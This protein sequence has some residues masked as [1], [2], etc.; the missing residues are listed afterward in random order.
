MNILIKPVVTEKSM[1]DVTKSKFTF[2]V[3]RDADKTMIKKEIETQFNVNVIAIR[4]MHVKGKR[5][6]V[7]ARRAEVKESVAKKAIV[8]LKAGQKI[9]LFD[10]AA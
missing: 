6:R 9:A 7:G 3:N 4:T 5:K 2:I 8:T 1:E 10:M